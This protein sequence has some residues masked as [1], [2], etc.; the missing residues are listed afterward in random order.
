ML[1]EV[2]VRAARP[3]DARAVHAHL[4]RLTAE[5]DLPLPFEAADVG[6]LDDVRAWMAVAERDPAGLV[7][8]ADDGARVVGHLSCTGRRERPWAHVTLLAVAVERGHRGAGTGTALVEEA[9]AWARAAP[10]V[11]RVELAVLADRE[12]TLGWY[13]RLGFEVEGR[14]R[15]AVKVR[16]EL[17]DDVVCAQLV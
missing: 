11:R 3:G 17:V 6:D 14:R 5:P 8:V 10:A 16:G 4:R 1:D 9:L 13:R 7:L 12:R 2:E 15:A